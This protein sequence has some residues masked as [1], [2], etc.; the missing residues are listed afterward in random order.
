MEDVYT[1]LAYWRFYRRD[2]TDG[3]I[4]GFMDYLVKQND[5]GGGL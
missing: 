5:A 2:S 4:E 3:S 1:I